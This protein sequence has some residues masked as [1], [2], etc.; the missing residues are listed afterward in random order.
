MPAGMFCLQVLS[1][2]CYH[3]PHLQGHSFTMQ[4]I[5]SLWWHYNRVQLY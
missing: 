2:H 4:L 3:T 5:L 1:L